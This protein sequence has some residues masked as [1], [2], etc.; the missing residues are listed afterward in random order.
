M[1]VFKLTIAYDGT[2]YEGW[3]IQPNG[4]TIQ[5]TLEK[6][7]AKIFCQKIKVVGAGRTDAGVHAEGQTA[8]V[9]LPKTWGSKELQ[10]S[11]NALLPK[12]IR[13]IDVEAVPS[14]F[15]A[16]FSAKGKVYQYK[17]CTNKVLPPHLRDYV[18]HYTYPLDLKLLQEILPQFT[19][20]RNF[21]AFANE[22]HKSSAE[23]SPIKN[24][25]QIEFLPSPYGFDLSFHGDGFLYKMVRNLTGT[26]LDIARGK[27]SPDCIEKIFSSEDRRLAPMGAPPQG[28]TLLKVLY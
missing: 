6:I 7:F 12:D 18:L 24:L 5:E 27:S 17:V 1:Q 23:T 21:K 9:L 13:I 15:H 10:K 25:K 2:N 22:N 3:Q 11:L 19:G 14:H 16:R 28:L 20:K 26:I 8:H 4:T